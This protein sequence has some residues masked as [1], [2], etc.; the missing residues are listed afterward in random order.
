MNG[1][2][3]ILVAMDTSARSLE[4]VCYVGNFFSKEDTEV[5]LFHVETHIPESF[6]D[7]NLGAG[8]QQR[9]ADVKS[10]DLETHKLMNKQLEDARTILLNL[11]FP[12]KKITLKH[13]KSVRGIAR[14]VIDESRKGFDAVVA[15]RTGIS[16]VKD[17]IMGNVAT[18]L[19][20]KI[21]GIP[22]IIVGKYS[23]PRKT[24]IA[25]DG[26]EGAIRAVECIARMMTRND[27]SIKICYVIRTITDIYR[28]VPYDVQELEEEMFRKNRDIIEPI[29][30]NTVTKLVVAGFKPDNISHEI[31]DKEFSRARAIVEDATAN[32]F[33]TIVVGRRGLSLVE[34]FFIGRVS[35]KILQLG[36][37]AAI[38]I[39]N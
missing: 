10:W 32:N 30:E 19:V 35:K 9:M 33:G 6:W 38:W 7:M 5:E 8:F 25:F 39:V 13:Q 14:D 17:L 36:D 11:G 28:T 3:K 27:S 22:L 24:L 31:K 1:D 15:G 20:G 34:E 29:I 16:Q 2:K 12:Y 18:K 21:M 4:A 26:S 23:N 37:R